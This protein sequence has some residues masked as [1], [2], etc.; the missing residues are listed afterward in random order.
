M[1]TQSQ[2]PS[3]IYN[4]A[5]KIDTYGA[6]LFLVVSLG[7]FL[8]TLASFRQTKGWSTAPSYFSLLLIITVGVY[9]IVSVNDLVLLL[10]AWALVS[11]AAYALVAVK[12]DESALEG[13]SKYAL[14]G[15]AASAFLLFGIAILIG[16]TGATTGMSTIANVAVSE[17]LPLTLIALIM[18]IVGIGFKIGIVPFHGWMPDVYG[19]VNP[20]TIS[21]IAAILKVSGVVALL[22]IVYPF[23]S[24]LG[25][26][27]L[28]LFAVLSIITM[29]FG[30]VAAL[31]QRNVQRMMAY[32]SIAHVG[33]ILVGFAAAT[34]G[35][36][37]VYGVQGV[38]LHLTTYV[39]ATIGIFVALAYLVEK[40]V[41]TDLDGIGGLWRKM[42]ALSVAIVILLLSLIGMPPLIGFWS[43][44]VYLFISPIEVAPW[45]TLVA[46]INTGISVGYYGQIIKSI[47]QTQPQKET[48][49][50][51]ERFKDPEMVVIIIAAAL[52]IL[53]GLGIVSF[54]APFLTF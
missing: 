14:M 30:N 21:F 19:G 47:F 25:D 11:V 31:I 22:R 34:S 37:A 9:Y 6:F 12:K 53:L 28:I 1:V 35:A 17:N 48:T 15:V 39:L 50:A 49:E 18:L 51:K 24:L 46:I 40:G 26:R 54:I 41:K 43:K 7:A 32:S 16:L 27:W 8:V 20:I 29:T 44:F 3:I 13:A 10:A 4:G 52:T 45:L 38:A 23:A 36:G 2:G 5:L 42:P 33:Y